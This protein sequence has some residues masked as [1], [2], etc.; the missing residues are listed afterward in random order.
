VESVAQIESIPHPSSRMV[1][2]PQ[3]SLRSSLFLLHSISSSGSLSAPRGE[4]RISRPY[5]NRRCG[6]QAGQSDDRPCS[7]KMCNSPNV[8]TLRAD[9]RRPDP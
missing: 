3:S 6:Q 5:S 9:H 4:R 1:Q 8:G 7:Q 2:R